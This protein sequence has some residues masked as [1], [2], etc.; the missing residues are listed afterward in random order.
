MSDKTYTVYHGK[1][2]CKTCNEEVKTIR[3][4]PST[5]I[6]TWMCSNKHLSRVQV[7]QIG[8]KKKKD[9]ERKERK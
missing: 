6:G 4:Y 5:G 8:Y 9:Y 1:F 7:Y 2:L 3:I